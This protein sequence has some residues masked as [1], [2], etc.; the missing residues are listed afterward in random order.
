MGAEEGLLGRG[1]GINKGV[2]VGSHYL[3]VE[4]RDWKAGVVHSPI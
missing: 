4:Q 2:E 3:P 1:S